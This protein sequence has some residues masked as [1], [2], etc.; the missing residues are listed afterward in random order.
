MDAP[1]DF[2]HFGWP[3]MS[4]L[5]VLEGFAVFVTVVVYRK[6]GFSG[7]RKSTSFFYTAAA[8]SYLL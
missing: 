3:T 1:T 7:A 8:A 5:H 6:K 4:N 2:P